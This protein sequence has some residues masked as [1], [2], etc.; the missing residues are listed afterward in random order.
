MN[1][2]QWKGFFE[3]VNVKRKDKKERLM[4]KF[5]VNQDHMCKTAR[6]GTNCLDIESDNRQQVNA[7]EDL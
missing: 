1:D 7:S 6:H 5:P 2:V 3:L 4:M